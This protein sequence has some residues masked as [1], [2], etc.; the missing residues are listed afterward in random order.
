MKECS[1]DSVLSSLKY[2][3]VKQPC[4][5]LCATSYRKLYIFD[6]KYE[7]LSALLF[8]AIYSIKTEMI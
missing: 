7:N 6:I 8:C 1:A 2:F 5:L 3:K 4:L